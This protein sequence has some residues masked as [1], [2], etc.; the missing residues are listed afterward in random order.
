MLPYTNYVLLILIPLV[1][2]AVTTPLVRIGAIKNGVVDQPGR[3]KI[4]SEA[5]PLLG[6][7]SIYISIMVSLMVLMPL[8]GKL[9]SL[10][11][12]SIVVITTGYFDDRYNLKPLVKLAGQLLAAA[13]VVFP[14]IGILTPLIELFGRF[15]FPGFVTVLGMILFIALM[16]N[17]FNLIDGMDGLAVGVAAILFLGMVVKTLV[18]GGSANILALQLIGFGACIGFLPYNFNPAKIYMGDTGSMLLGFLL[19]VTFLFSV[20]V[21]NF[22]GALVLGAIYIFAYPL[23]DVA[24]AIYRR[25]R[26]QCSILQADRC[27]IHHLFQ[28]M[29]FSVR[30]T[31]VYIY[32][33]NLVFVTFGVALIYFKAAA[34]FILVVGIL[35]ALAAVLLIRKFANMG[36]AQGRMAII[37]SPIKNGKVKAD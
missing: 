10:M 22:S 13:I 37:H 17:A 35:T 18:S 1:I 24:F 34:G 14:N 19:S 3:H 2:S 23:L 31:V 7:L 16:I 30:K 5:K 9:I 25:V 8:N 29:G 28:G 15:Y 4:H 26:G 11:L 20:T 6:G 12:A 33:I 27:H 36:V 21:S 32:L